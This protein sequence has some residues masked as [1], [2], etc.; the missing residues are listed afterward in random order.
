MMIDGVGLMISFG[1]PAWPA[2]LKGTDL[3]TRFD[4]A[5]AVFGT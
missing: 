5:F 3:L 1:L 4:S 2:R